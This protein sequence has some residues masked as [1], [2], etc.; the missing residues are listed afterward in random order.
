MDAT[1]H[2]IGLNIQVTT[3][4]RQR[5]CFH[6]EHRFFP[7]QLMWDIEVQYYYLPPHIMLCRG[8]DLSLPTRTKNPDGTAFHVIYLLCC[9]LYQL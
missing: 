5:D 7:T 8:G 2:T 1:K 6:L 3:L 9:G 4:I